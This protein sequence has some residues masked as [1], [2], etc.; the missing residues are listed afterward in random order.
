MDKEMSHKMANRGRE[1]K[2]PKPEDLEKHWLVS[3]QMHME[4][5]TVY[6]LFRG[7]E[8]GL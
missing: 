3:E 5:D 6:L 4:W 8:K 1:T 2:E 7:Q